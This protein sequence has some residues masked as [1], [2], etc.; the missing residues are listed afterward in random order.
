MYRALQQMVEDLA[1]FVGVEHA[2]VHPGIFDSE[3]MARTIVMAPSLLLAAGG[4]VEGE[5]AGGETFEYLVPLTLY[6]PVR[7]E[8]GKSRTES[9]LDNLVVPILGYLPGYECSPPW[10]GPARSLSAVNLYNAVIDSKGFALW[11]IEWDQPIRLPRTRGR[12]PM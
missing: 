12:S 9:V 3:E 10:S 4:L 1:K 6:L 5:Y 7:D 2:S 8:P 11:S